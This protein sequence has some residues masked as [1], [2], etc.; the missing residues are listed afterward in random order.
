MKMDEKFLSNI[1]TSGE[2]AMHAINENKFGKKFY[3]LGPVEMNSIFEKVKKI[4]LI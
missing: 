1:V 3:H 4:K 2:A